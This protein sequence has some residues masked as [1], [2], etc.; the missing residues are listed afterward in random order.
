M[1]FS[2]TRARRTCHYCLRRPTVWPRA[3]F[4]VRLEIFLTS[5]SR[6]PWLLGALSDYKLFRGG[7][8]QKE[9]KALWGEEGGRGPPFPP[10]NY[11]ISRRQRGGRGGGMGQRC[12]GWRGEAFKIPVIMEREKRRRCIDMGSPSPRQNAFLMR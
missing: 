8:R 4:S 7:R 9:K 5:S 2:S 1:P 3:N 10:D 6:R 11:P 12:H